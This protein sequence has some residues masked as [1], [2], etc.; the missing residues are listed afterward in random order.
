MELLFP[1]RFEQ[2][3]Q[4]YRYA[5]VVHERLALIMDNLADEFSTLAGNNLY[6][7]AF[8]FKEEDSV[9]TSHFIIHFTKHSKGFKLIKQVYYDFDNIGA[10]L[11]RNGVYTFD[12]K[13]MG[14]DTDLLTE[15]NTWAL[16]SEIFKTYRDH[17][18]TAEDLFLDHHKDTNYCASHYVK[19]LRYLVENQ[20]LNAVFTD[21]IQ[22]KVSVLISPACHLTFL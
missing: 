3:R 16:A 22:H 1:T 17:K 18:L 8:K 21:E 11:E 20:K 6:S 4:D 7:C 14:R 10:T 15:A 19:A 13:Q 12:V 9:A 2:L 5:G